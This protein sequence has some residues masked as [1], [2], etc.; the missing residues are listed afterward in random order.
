[1]T[2]FLVA[3]MLMVG[4]VMAVLLPPLAERKTSSTLSSRVRDARTEWETLRGQQQRG[5]L[6]PTG[7]DEGRRRLAEAL[8]ADLVETG[9]PLSADR[10]GRL[11]A[12]ALAVLI[13]ASAFGLYAYLG[14]GGMA[15]QPAGTLAE[16]PAG[17]AAGSMD[18]V[19]QRLETRLREQPQDVQGWELL[20]Q[21]YLAQ[22]RFSEAEAAY[23]RAYELKGDEPTL[24]V[25]YAEAMARARD[26]DLSGRPSELLAKALELAPND[27][28]TLWF[29]GLAAY[30][31]GERERTVSLWQKLLAMQ[32]P[33]SEAEQ[34]ISRQL[35]Q[36]QAEIAPSPA[37]M[38]T[39][40]NRQS[41]GTAAT[42]TEL[43]VAVSLSDDLQ[44]RVAPGSTVFVYARAADGPRAPLALV[45]DRVDALPLTVTLSD[46]QAMMPQL[47]L[48]KFATV[49]VVA[50]VSPSGQA[51]PQAGD[52]I[53]VAGP[54]S[55]EDQQGPVNVVIDEV[56][57]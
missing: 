50:R 7:Y 18:A 13:P 9:T 22:G 26:G 48:S 29:G 40:A 34:A 19:I 15:L 28:L 51:T 25:R 44:A 5:V 32:Q 4:L 2:Y 20:G 23:A 8:F 14:G 35:A 54:I 46:S 36:I 31:R 10:R 30:Q 53:G 43:R 11:L 6:D 37:D 3:T 42:G 27:E 57:E 49:E 1:M 21:S 38:A 39:A 33:G 55:P 47:T 24:L 17:D 56:V 41:G 45:S 52:L 16:G 12:V